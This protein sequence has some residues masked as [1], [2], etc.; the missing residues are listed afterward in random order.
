LSDLVLFILTHPSSS[1][2]GDAD[3]VL[4]VL[5]IEGCVRLGLVVECDAHLL[6]HDR[7][8]VDRGT[9]HP[10]RVVRRRAVQRPEEKKRIK[11]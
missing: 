3:V 5:G 6:G 8:G 7:R 9:H 1:G 4:L 2:E 10:V 11:H